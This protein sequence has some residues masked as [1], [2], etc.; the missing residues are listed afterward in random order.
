[1][2][3]QNRRAPGDSRL[4]AHR[5]ERP[6]AQAR[7]RQPGLQ[8]RTS[9]CRHHPPRRQEARH[10]LQPLPRRAP[11]RQVD[12]LRNRRPGPAANHPRRLGPLPRGSRRPAR[13]RPTRRPPGHGGRKPPRTRLLRLLQGVHILH[14]RHRR[15]RQ[16]GRPHHD[17]PPAP[18]RRPFGPARRTRRARPGLRAIP[19][20]RRIHRHRLLTRRQHQRLPLS[21]ARHRGVRRP[22]DSLRPRPIPE[23]QG[24]RRPMLH[25]PRQTQLLAGHRPHLRG[26]QPPGGAPLRQHHDPPRRIRRRV[27]GA[28]RVHPPVAHPQAGH[29]RRA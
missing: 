16:G 22:E 27:G 18:H 15:G 19:L 28:R 11:P 2:A 24:H 17:A 21:R 5:P 10:P 8:R 9:Q 12:V 1:M 6:P 4:L 7:P 29:H 26:V 20:P 25:H 13:P 23:T 14:R 3:A